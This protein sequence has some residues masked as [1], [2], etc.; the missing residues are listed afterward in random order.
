MATP[1]V[2]EATRVSYLY[3]VVLADRL[4]AL[5]GVAGVGGAALS[6][7]DSDR[8]VAVVADVAR[9]DFIPS[10]AEREDT[11]WLERAVRAHESVLE[12]CLEPGPVLPMRFATTVRDDDDVRALL[13]E[14]QA[15]FTAALERLLGHR[16]WGVKALLGDPEALAQHVLAVRADLA[17]R[18]RALAGRSP[19]AA[20]LAR[21][22]LAGE[23]AAAGDDLSAEVA[24]SSHRRLA[25]IAADASLLTGSQSRRER[26]YLNAAYLVAEAEEQ[27][28]EA[29]VAELDREHAELG[30]RFELTGPWPPYNFVDHPER[31]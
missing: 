23:T 1:T 10:G 21:K 19:G 18:E 12:R 29:V 8:L 20:Y 9:R 13:R 22:R 28:F 5:D 31:E 4:P 16:E 11:A 30:L 27:E 3:G 2:A 15:E 17:A 7:V 6:F 14:H 26:V 25:E 24:Q